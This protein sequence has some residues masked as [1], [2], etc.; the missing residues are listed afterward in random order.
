VIWESPPLPESSI[1]VRNDLDADT[2]AKVARF[3]AEYGKGEGTEAERQRGVLKGL[4]Y[5]GFK[6]AGNEYLRPVAQMEAADALAQARKGGDA[7]R[8]AAAQK[9][10]DALAAP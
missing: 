6:P 3:F 1:V 2:K 10:L 9:A 5:G 7:G 4:A 8:I